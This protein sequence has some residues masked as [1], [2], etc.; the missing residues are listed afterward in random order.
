MKKFIQSVYC[1]KQA[2]KSVPL[3]AAVEHSDEGGS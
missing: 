3:G 2:P 1:P